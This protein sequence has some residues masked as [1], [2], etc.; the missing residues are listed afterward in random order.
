MFVLSRI[1]AHLPVCILLGACLVGPA[2]ARTPVPPP[3]AAVQTMGGEIQ[4]YWNRPLL[5]NVGL[6]VADIEQSLGTTA[7]GFDRFGLTQDS[8]L[9]ALTQGHS[10]RGL[11]AGAMY[12]RG[13]YTLTGDHIAIAV[14]DATLRMRAEDHAVFDVINAT[15]ERPFFADHVMAEPSTDG[16]DVAVRT[17]DL[18]V[19]AA[20]AQR[21]SRLEI[22]GWQLGTIHVLSPIHGSG[23]TPVIEICPPSKRWPG[24]PVPEH[25]GETYQTDVLL[26]SLTLQVTSCRHCT[27]PKGEGSIKLTPVTALRNNVNDDSVT[28]TVATDPLGTSSARFSADVP[29]REMFSAPCAPYGNDQHPY[30]AWNLYRINADG[31]L[32]Q[33]GRSGVKH[34]HIATNGECVENP[35]S[36]HVLG[37]GCADAYGTGD[38]DA[39]AELGPRSEIIPA[40]GEWGRCGSIYDPACTGTVRGFLGYDDSAYRLIVPEAAMSGERNAGASYFFE[41]WYVVRDDINPYNSMASLPFA[42]DWHDQNKLWSVNPQGPSSMGPVIDRWVDPSHPTAGSLSTELKTAHGR[43]KVAVRTA[44]LPD[45]RYRY[46]YALMNVDFAIAQTQ[47]EAPNLKIL[48]SQGLTGF[49]IPLHD[50]IKAAQATFTDIDHIPDQQWTAAT[51]STQVSWTGPNSNALTW[52]TLYVFSII[53]NG[54]PGPAKLTLNTATKTSKNEFTIDSLAPVAAP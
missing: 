50:G 22:A 49:A 20:L 54:R 48:S 53:A 25:P 12:V 19:S 1:V 43:I 31:Q 41:G 26:P 23:L 34:G 8:Q 13:G 5:E 37:R 35:G 4:I 32:H 9:T 21:L 29:W 30:L 39:P 46:D 24:M 51:R 36:N 45:G 47:G 18:R 44:A 33:L 10:L 38:N 2:L 42:M 11:S 6:H 14:H 28:A 3:S 27:G 15:G 17:M 40:T 7:E 52:G 16:H